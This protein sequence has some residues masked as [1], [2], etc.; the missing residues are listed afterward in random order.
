MAMI[1]MQNCLTTLFVWLRLCWCQVFVSQHSLTAITVTLMLTQAFFV[2]FLS[3]PPQYMLHAC[4]IT[5]TYTG[6]ICRILLDV[7]IQWCPSVIWW[8]STISPG[9]S[10]RHQSEWYLVDISQNDICQISVR[11]I[12]YLSDIHQNYLCQI[13]LSDINQKYMSDI[14]KN[15][16]CQI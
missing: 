6:K 16:I 12:L 15:D 11:R 1:Q 14:S 10:L 9:A 4:W 2:S 5:K 8:I 3:Q 7:M 13:C